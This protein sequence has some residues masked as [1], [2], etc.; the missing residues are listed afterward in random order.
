MEQYYYLEVSD[1]R[2]DMRE[3]RDAPYEACGA[4]LK[5]A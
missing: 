3:H 4:A 1:K 2:R 5:K